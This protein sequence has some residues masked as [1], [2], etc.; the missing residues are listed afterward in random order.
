MHLAMNMGNGRH[1]SVFVI[2]GAAGGA[3]CKNKAAYTSRIVDA[4]RLEIAAL[5][6]SHV[7]LVGD[8]NA[9][10]KHIPAV[11]HLLDHDHFVDVG[12][13][14]SQFG[15]VD[16]EGTCLTANAKKHYRRDYAFVS[17][18]MLEHVADFAVLHD[19]PMAISPHS[20]LRLTLKFTD[21]QMQV[22]R[23]QQP[24]EF[25]VLL[26]NRC[27]ELFGNMFDSHSAKQEAW[28]LFP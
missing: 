15:G 21:A 22:S 10:P 18:S 14:A 24:T 4:I 9:D 26:H 11:T 7:L 3:G 5:K 1:Y 12:A 20:R 17:P 19:V 23:M 8:L 27:E 28:R 16:N 6:L 25:H 2:Y 13:I